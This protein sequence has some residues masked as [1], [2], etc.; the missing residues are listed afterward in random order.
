VEDSPLS[1]LITLSVKACHD[2]TSVEFEVLEIDLVWIRLF[3]EVWNLLTEKLLHTCKPVGGTN[4]VPCSRI[5]VVVVL[6][7]SQLDILSSLEESDTRA[8]SLSRMWSSC[9]LA[10]PFKKTGPSRLV[11]VEPFSYRGVSARDFENELQ[12]R[13]HPFEEA[14]V[15]LNGLQESS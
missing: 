14:K 13:F 11:A 5:W 8:C 3:T 10:N 9:V 1:S 15:A 2:I 7:R 12:N 6:K 4:A